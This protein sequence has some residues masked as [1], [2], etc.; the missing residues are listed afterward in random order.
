MGKIKKRSE[1]KV[2][3]PKGDEWNPYY[4]YIYYPDGR[5]VKF[6]LS[7]TNDKVKIYVDS[8][9]DE[10]LISFFRNYF[11]K[12]KEKILFIQWDGAIEFNN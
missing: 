11:N 10:Q 9:Y 3:V 7:K 12:L 5:K 4:G 6:A 1:L 8:D 2:W